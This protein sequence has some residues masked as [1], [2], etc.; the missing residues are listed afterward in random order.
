MKENNKPL[1]N[2]DDKEEKALKKG[3]NELM[4]T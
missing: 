2:E 1:D 3:A 4:K